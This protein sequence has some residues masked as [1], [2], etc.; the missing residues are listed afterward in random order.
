MA[1]VAILGYYF[2]VGGNIHC[3]GEISYDTCILCTTIV[4]VIRS[5]RVIRL[6]SPNLNYLIGI[7]AILVYISVAVLFVQPTANPKASGP[8]CIVSITESWSE[9]S[10]SGL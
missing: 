5:I 2:W 4:F 3:Q 6:T 9:L 1:G 8:L 10:G 7:G